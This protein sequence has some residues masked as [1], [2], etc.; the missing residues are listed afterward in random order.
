MADRLVT[1]ASFRDLPQALLAKGALDS[2]GIPCFLANE[3]IVRLDW[4]LASA[5]GGIRLQVPEGDAEKALEVLNDGIPAVFFS[6]KGELY[7]QPQCPNCDSLNISYQDRNRWVTFLSWLMLSIPLPFLRSCA[8]CA[9]S[10]ATNGKG[11]S[12]PLDPIGVP[13]EPLVDGSL[14]ASRFS[15]RTSVLIPLMRP[16]HRGLRYTFGRSRR[17]GGSR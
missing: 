2:T 7:E 13:R 15:I 12:L 16:G 5:V 14:S 4:L 9:P 17:R 1:I 6:E 10:A 8:G 11:R 3:N